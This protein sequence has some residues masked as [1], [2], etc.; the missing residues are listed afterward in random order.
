MGLPGGERIWI[1]PLA[2]GSITIIDRFH[3]GL[4]FP[5]NLTE[6]I[7]TIHRGQEADSRVNSSEVSGRIF[8]SDVNIRRSTLEVDSRTY[9]EEAD[10]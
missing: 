3:L 7:T 5:L 8:L 1:F 4:G 9:K 10:A 6:L 2:D